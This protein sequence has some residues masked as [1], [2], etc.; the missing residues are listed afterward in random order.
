MR[1][2]TLKWMIEEKGLFVDM[3][4]RTARGIKKIPNWA[5]QENQTRSWKKSESER[6]EEE[7]GRETCEQEDQ[8]SIWEP[9]GHIAKMAEFCRLRC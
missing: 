7:R 4:E 8:E 5:C 1:P 3:R 2:R 6:A 9:R